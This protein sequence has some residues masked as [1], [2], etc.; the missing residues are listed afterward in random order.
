MQAD[1][2]ILEYSMEVPQEAKSRATLQLSNC[3]T[4]YLP[5]RYK[6]SYLKGHVHPNANSSN[7]HNCQTTEGAQV[8]IDRW[9]DNVV[10]TMEY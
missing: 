5:Q 1:M 7:V 6:C 4:R 9:M 2:D 3:T 10:E 8:S